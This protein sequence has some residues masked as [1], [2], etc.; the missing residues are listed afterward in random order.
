MSKLVEQ[1]FDIYNFF[2]TSKFLKIKQSFK[3]T[4]KRL[5]KMFYRY[6]TVFARTKIDVEIALSS[7]SYFNLKLQ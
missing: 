7:R 2:L 3:L 5:R 6:E 1:F 4:L